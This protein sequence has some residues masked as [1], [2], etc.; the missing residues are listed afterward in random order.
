MVFFFLQDA[1]IK[2]PRA[3]RSCQQSIGTSW[4][5][6]KLVTV[7]PQSDPNVNRSVWFP[8]HAAARGGWEFHISSFLRVPQKAHLSGELTQPAFQFCQSNEPRQTEADSRSSIRMLCKAQAK[9]A[10]YFKTC[11]FLQL[12]GRAL[13]VETPSS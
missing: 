6:D 13:F 11:C 9:Q 3:A 5:A 10:H 2:A 1:H 8:S 7:A 4:P 12:K